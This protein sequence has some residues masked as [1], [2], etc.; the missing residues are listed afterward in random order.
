M[1]LRSKLLF[2]AGLALISGCAANAQ[3]EIAFAP[4]GEV[5]KV[6]AAE[7]EMPYSNKKGE[8]FENKLTQL[9]SA[10]LNR[11]I[12]YVYW[13]DP[14]YF[15]RDFLNKGL[16]DVVIGVDAGDPRVLTTK[17]Y[18]R[19][20][21]TFISRKKDDL[22]LQ[23]WDSAVLRSVKQIAYIPG[24]P[25]E[26]M[27]RA[28]GRYSDTFNYNKELVGFKSRRNQY[29]KY[30]TSKIV[31]DISSGKAEVAVLWGPSAGRYVKASSVPLTM[32]VVPD[33]STRADGEKVGQHY[34]TAMA[35]RKGETDLL[36]QL[37][38]FISD[39][40]SEIE[41]LLKDEGIPL[42]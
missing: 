11:K 35:V 16:C 33:N 1:I 22:D 12:K 30:D 41:D 38:H 19:S 26:V 23:D 28:I 9:L 34:S 2:L 14:R 40:Q 37:N 17:P 31:S 24:T 6:C 25:A 36:K 8:G 29:V 15:V 18:Y 21:Y 20:A 7:D 13:Q 42:L 3:P 27:I 4:T 39:Q 10:N 32:T 5:L